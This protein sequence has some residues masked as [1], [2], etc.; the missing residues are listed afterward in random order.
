MHSDRRSFTK[1]L[2]AGTSLAAS[3]SRVLGA[4]DR[5]RVGIIGCGGMGTGNWRTFLSQPDVS[6]VAVCD[7][8]D[9]FRQRAAELAKEKVADYKDFRH[10][11]DRN[12]I[13]AVIVATP[14]HWHALLTVMACRA[15]KDVYV[16]KPLSLTV[17][18]GRVMV[19]TARKQK[20]IVQVGAQQ[21]SGKHYAEAMKLIQEG[22]L[23]AIHKI[24]ANWTRNMM[25]GFQPRELKTGLTSALDWDMWLGP[26]PY[27]GFDPL[28]FS[29]NWRWFWDYSGGQ[30]T[31]WG[32][33]SLDIARWALGAKAPTAIAAFGG[34]YELKDG[35]QT[36]DV[37]DALFSFPGCVVSWTGREIN[38]VEAL[39]PAP[40][41]RPLLEF[42]GTKGNMVLTREEF[43][44]TP[45]VWTGDG[46]D[47]RTPAMQPIK[48]TGGQLSQLHIRNF[49]DCVKSRKTPNADVE[50][51]YNTIVMCH[52]GNIA[53]KVGRVL[54]WDSETEE[55][56]GDKEANQLLS[57]P[58]RKPWTLGA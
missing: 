54:R 23:G 41:I 53:T 6:P 30:M 38:G 19:D 27:V 10:L 8:Y 44:V 13:D 37:Q 36:P 1:A 24:S 34:R 11:L 35:G 16:E 9:P 48:G 20:R 52:L 29:Y 22:A 2:V 32:A 5:I 26:A 3:A 58:Y 15:G 51:G 12:D 17:R 49:L 42:H 25:P 28:R 57:R 4:N 31:N 14:D 45:E 46:Q 50:E 7:V 21:R 39:R 43:T 55:V 47:R 56:I 40:G 33:H 18:E